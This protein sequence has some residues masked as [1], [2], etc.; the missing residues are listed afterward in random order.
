[1]E[2]LSDYLLIAFSSFER[3]RPDS[4]Y[5]RGY[6][7]ALIEVRDRLAP[8]VALAEHLRQASRAFVGE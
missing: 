8:S 3:D 5:Q 1:M 7:S 2:K 4:D 6:L